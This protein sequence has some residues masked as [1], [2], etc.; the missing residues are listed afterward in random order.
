MAAV[1]ATVVVRNNNVDFALKQLKR[2]LKD[3]DTMKKY[4]EHLAFEKPGIKRRR[5]KL[6]AIRRAK[7]EL[8]QYKRENKI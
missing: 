5:K 1:N 3:A 2:K 8:E 7:Y 6:Q 4:E